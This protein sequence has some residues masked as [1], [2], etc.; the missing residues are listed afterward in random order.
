MTQQ[1]R[2]MTP[3]HYQRLALSKEADQEVIRQRIYDSGVNATRI[4]NGLRGLVDECGELAGAVKRWLEYGG[5]LDINNIK[6]E[7]GD[8]LWRLSQILKAVD[9]TLEEAME[10]NLRKLK[11][12]YGDGIC[13]PAKAA[14]AAR[15]RDAERDALDNPFDGPLTPDIVLCPKCGA[16]AHF[17][18]VSKYDRSYRDYYQCKHPRCAHSWFATTASVGEITLDQAAEDAQLDCSWQSVI[19]NDY[20]PEDEALADEYAKTVDVTPGP[21]WP[22]PPQIHELTGKG[23]IADTSDRLNKSYNRL[24]VYC[25]RRPVYKHNTAGVCPDCAAD[26]RGQPMPGDKDVCRSCDRP[27]AYTGKYWEHSE[28]T[29]RHIAVPKFREDKKPALDV[30]NSGFAQPPVESEEGEY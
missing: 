25:N 17:Y 29:Y 21:S 6:E 8:A 1:I 30:G 26:R 2:I 18:D 23:P 24:C 7:A 12:R 15:D 13:E 19:K 27:I 5:E 16:E 28:G 14:E 11:V 4:E 3:N 22:Q 20:R 9:I 10:A